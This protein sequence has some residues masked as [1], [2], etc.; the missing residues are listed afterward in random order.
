M[1]DAI[2]SHPRFAPFVCVAVDAVDVGD[3]GEVLEGW[4]LSGL[5]LEEFHSGFGEE[6]ADGE[7]GVVREGGEDV[8]DFD[9]C[10]GAGCCEEEMVFAVVEVVGCFEWLLCRVIWW[11]GGHGVLLYCL[12]FII[13]GGC[14]A[15]YRKHL[16]VK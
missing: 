15:L 9:G 12:L 4:L 10:Y 16:R 11:N 1:R 13:V 6:Q 14:S 3:G 5:V 8:G 2:T 7:V